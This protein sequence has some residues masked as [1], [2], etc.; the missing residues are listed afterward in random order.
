[1]ESRHPAQLG[2]SY[3]GR[4]RSATTSTSPPPPPLH[5]L[6]GMAAPL[7]GS[8]LSHRRHQQ[9]RHQRGAAASGAMWR[10]GRPRTAPLL[11]AKEGQ[12]TGEAGWGGE[13]TEGKLSLVSA[14][15]RDSESVR[16]ATCSPSG[17]PS[18][19][20]TLKEAMENDLRA[21]SSQLV[22]SPCPLIVVL[23][24]VLECCVACMVG[25]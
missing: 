8:E 25:G 18:M 15:I 4:R 3:D 20:A 17:S 11:L 1:M 12:A 14:D 5:R 10:V 22:G 6:P 16:V 21:A 24:A 23:D 9:R 7:P 2:P 19:P 13:D